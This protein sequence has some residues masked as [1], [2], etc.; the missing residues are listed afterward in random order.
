[1]IHSRKTL[2]PAEKLKWLLDRMPNATARDDLVEYFRQVL[3]RHA[4]HRH[5]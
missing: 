5:G 4:A 2:S 3:L 1:M